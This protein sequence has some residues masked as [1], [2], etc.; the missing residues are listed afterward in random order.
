MKVVPSI[1]SGN[2]VNI[3]HSIMQLTKKFD[4]LH[5]D[6]E[7]GNFVPNLTFGIKTLKAIRQ[8]TDLPFSV[9]LM[10]T[11]PDQYLEDLYRL[12]CSHI[13][14]HVESS[15]YLIR[16]LS[17]IRQHQIKACIALNPISD[18]RLYDY[19][20][21]EI[22]AVLYLTS[23]IDGKGER[24]QPRI[25]SKMKALPEKECWVDGGID[26]N[27]MVQLPPFVDYAVMGRAIYNP[28]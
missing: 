26:Q 28:Q 27:I 1:A 2:L 9:H 6:I 20:L 8:I 17:A 5:I 14:V 15:P 13:F 12:K 21:D 24:F 7:D 23:E 18:I 11:N 25:V 22:D 19:L 16:Y 3:E 10:V 4:N